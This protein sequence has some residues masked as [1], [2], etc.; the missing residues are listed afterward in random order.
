MPFVLTAIPIA[1]AFSP[2]KTPSRDDSNRLIVDEKIAHP[3]NKKLP[4]IDVSR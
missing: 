3:A 4:S 1:R 2:V